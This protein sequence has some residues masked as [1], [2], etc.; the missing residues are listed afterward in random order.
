MVD[1]NTTSG[2]L[3]RLAY[4]KTGTIDGKHAKKNAG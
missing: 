1:I 4:G 2:G 3:A